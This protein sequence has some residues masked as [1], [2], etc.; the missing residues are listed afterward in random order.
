MRESKVQKTLREGYEADGCV[1]LKL[2]P[3]TDIPL[4]FPDLLIV[5]PNG[6]VRFVEVKRADGRVS[7]AQ[8]VWRDRLTRMGHDAMIVRPKE[9]A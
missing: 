3:G 9:K 2:N 5:M 8:E 7:P 6:R 1:V 4:G